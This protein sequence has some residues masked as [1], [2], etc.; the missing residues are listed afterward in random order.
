MSAH[1]PRGDS[2][3]CPKHLWR[4]GVQALGTRFGSRRAGDR[5]HRHPDRHFAPE[6]RCWAHVDECDTAGAVQPSAD[7]SGEVSTDFVEAP[8]DAS[9]PFSVDPPE[10]R[11]IDGAYPEASLAFDSLIN[12]GK[13]VIVPLSGSGFAANGCV[14][15][16]WYLPNGG[17]CFR[18][19]GLRRAGIHLYEVAVGARCWLDQ[20]RER[21]RI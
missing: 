9:F 3:S 4:S 15:V 11:V 8:A 5:L 21:R 2:A 7:T 10:P 12:R 14:Q 6:V 13:S 17:T 18:T 20:V 16:D 19:S 1:E